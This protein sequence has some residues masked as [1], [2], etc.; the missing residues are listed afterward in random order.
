MRTHPYA[1]S[2]ALDLCS[3]AALP[4]PTTRWVD[5]T[6]AFDAYVQQHA[7]TTLFYAGY[8]ANTD[9]MFGVGGMQRFYSMKRY[10][11]LNSVPNY[12]WVDEATIGLESPETLADGWGKKT[13]MG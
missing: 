2:R 4:P 3:P 9:M 12:F 11:G 7:I 13:A 1:H 6:A 5:T 8:A 10:L